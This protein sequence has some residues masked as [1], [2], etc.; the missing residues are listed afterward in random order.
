ME[1]TFDEAVEYLN[2]GCEII[3]RCNGYD[4]E[5]SQSENWVG[6]DISEGYV[7]LVL[8]NVIY[9][10]PKVVLQES[11]HFLS[12]DGDNVAIFLQ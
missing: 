7:S 2:E 3:L 12:E 6:G 4:Y 11:I 5:V 9:S 10:D 8:G 1:I